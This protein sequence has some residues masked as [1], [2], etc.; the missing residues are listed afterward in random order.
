MG[1]YSGWDSIFLKYSGEVFLERPGIFST[2]KITCC[3]VG[4]I[5]SEVKLQ[6][7]L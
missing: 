6:Y 2:I 1:I 7:R 5:Q 4:G 3:R